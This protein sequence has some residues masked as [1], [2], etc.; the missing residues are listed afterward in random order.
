VETAGVAHKDAHRKLDNLKCRIK[1]ARNAAD[2][3]YSQGDG[4]D[5][6]SY[7]VGKESVELTP[8]SWNMK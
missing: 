7:G 8:S 6:V 5:S 1:A 3:A 2:R 4:T